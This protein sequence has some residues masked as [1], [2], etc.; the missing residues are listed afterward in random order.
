MTEDEEVAVKLRRRVQKAAWPA[1]P[2]EKALAESG[3]AANLQ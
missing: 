1:R 3:S 2:G